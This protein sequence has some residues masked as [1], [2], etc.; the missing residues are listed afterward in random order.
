MSEKIDLNDPEVKAAIQAAV[1]EATAPLLAKRDQL[2]AENKK[3]KKDS[4]ISPEDYAE[5]E[6]ERDELKAQ[7]TKLGKDLKTATE[8]ADKATND[9]KS[10][11][12][13]T[14]NLLKDNGLTDALTKAGV[15]NAVNLKAARAMLGGQVQIVV[16]GDQRIAKVG[17][18]PLADF[19]GEWAKTDEGKHFVAAPGNSG[20]GGQG[21]QGGGGQGGKVEGKID[22]TDAER[23]A[24]FATKY[25]DLTKKE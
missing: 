13:F 18:K 25:P 6:R 9:L 15:T 5:I 12:N 20:G 11:Q 4:A 10:E 8:A 24:H 21:G 22:G 1:E 16:E 14:T 17:D 2:L 19:I 23:A 3:L 7:N